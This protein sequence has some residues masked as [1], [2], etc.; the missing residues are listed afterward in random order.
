MPFSFG[1]EHR[2]LNRRFKVYL[3][4]SGQTGIEGSLSKR[5]KAFCCFER[6]SSGFISKLRFG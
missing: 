1:F 5:D 2:F 4:K 3:T 6:N